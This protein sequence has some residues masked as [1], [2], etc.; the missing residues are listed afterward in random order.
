M[1]KLDMRTGLAVLAMLALPAAAAAQTPNM[2]PLAIEV[3]GGLNWAT[4]ELK[5]GIGLRGTPDGKPVA[6]AKQGGWTGAADLYWHLAR[7]SAVYIGWEQA[8]FKCKTEICG[9]DG[10]L[11]SAG[12]EFGFKFAALHSNNFNPWLRVGLLAHKAKFKE[13]SNLEENSVRSAGVEAGVGTDMAFMNGAIAI[14]PAIRYYRY[15]AGWD[16]GTP[17][18]KRLRKKI[19]WFQT[20]LG[21]QI[22][23]GR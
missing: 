8:G 6:A 13:G 14:V 3:R 21:L 2:K 17:D 16:L 22:R 10:K 23:A 15:N 1:R 7:R 19:G 18:A 12:P 9:S 4:T 5:N 20:D 11:W